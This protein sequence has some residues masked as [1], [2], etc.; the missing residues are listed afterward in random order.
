MKH[1]LVLFPQAADF[2]Q[3]QRLSALGAQGYR[4]YHEGFDLFRFPSNA[5]LLWFDIY[6]FVARLAEKYRTIRLDA[7]IS[8]HEQFGALAASLL[9]E[10]I[11]LPA[12]STRALLN[13]QHKALARQLLQRH[14]PDATVPFATFPY[15]VKSASEIALPFP[16]YTKP[17]KAAFSVLARR[18]DGFAELKQHI[19]FHPWETFIIKRLVRPFNDVVARLGVSEIDGHQML[20]EQLIDGVQVN[21]DG[22]V[23]Q[24]RIHVLGV[25]DA[26]MYP[27]TDAFL[28]WEYPSRLAKPFLDRIHQL[29]EAVVAALGIDHGLFNVELRLDEQTGACKVIEVNPRMARQFSDM[30]EAVDGINLHALAIRLALGEPSD[31]A[32][33]RASGGKRKFATSFVY[34]R[35]DGRP[36]D[37]FPA[38]ADIAALAQFDPNA[39]LI[40]FEKHGGGL[41]RELR[42]LQSY[43]YA[44]LN[45][46]ADSAA[47]LTEKYQRASAILGFP[48][49]P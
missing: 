14:V 7:I 22:F 45:M 27:G 39:Q 42:W 9:A 33:L 3:L 31:I 23:E 24:G 49:H 36:Q 35:F 43:R 5:N 40:T 8:S 29:T 47:E 4:F 1:V 46:A 41:K 2:L 26:L 34:R 30:Y 17:I 6:A 44:L 19:N 28:R 10:R 48:T 13:A 37:H 25:I 38:A 11:G 20:A 12:M 18:V 16:F 15:T 21:V 32:R